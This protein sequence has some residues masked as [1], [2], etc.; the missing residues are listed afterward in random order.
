M[1]ALFELF[2]HTTKHHNI[3]NTIQSE[4]RCLSSIVMSSDKTAPNY[5]SLMK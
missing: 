2:Q 1:T 3:K 5:S 4:M